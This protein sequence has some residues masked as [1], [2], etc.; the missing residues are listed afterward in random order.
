[1]IDNPLNRTVSSRGSRHYNS[2]LVESD[3]L[4]IRELADHRKKLLSEAANITNKKIAD[5]FGVSRH[6]IEKIIAVESWSHV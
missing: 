3:I 2:K 5:K 6:T 4:L 1:M